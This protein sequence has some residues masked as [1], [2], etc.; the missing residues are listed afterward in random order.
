MEDLPHHFFTD[1]FGG[2]P[3]PRSIFSHQISANASFY[4]DVFCP[5]EEAPPPPSL[6]RRG[7]NLP[8]FDI[9]SLQLNQKSRSFVHIFGLD[10]KKKKKE[11]RLYSEYDDV[12]MSAAKLRCVRASIKQ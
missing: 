2:A 6:R 11:K 3:R 8:L 5:T 4:D 10:A 9:P 12:A 7:R 1:I